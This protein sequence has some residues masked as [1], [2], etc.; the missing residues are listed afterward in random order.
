MTAD[1]APTY[2]A[3][4]VTPA[5][6]APAASSGG[7]GGG[8]SRGTVGKLWRSKSGRVMLATGVALVIV[9]YVFLRRGKAGLSA[10]AAAAAAA[11]TDGGIPAVAPDPLAGLGPGMVNASPIPDG[12]FNFQNPPDTPTDSGSSGGS[13]S[14]A[15]DV[16]LP[17]MTNLPPAT[18][19]AGGGSGTGTA[20]TGTATHTAPAARAKGYY[21]ASFGGSV[22]YEDGKGHARPADLSTAAKKA[23][24]AA[25]AAMHTAMK[26]NPKAG[27][28]NFGLGGVPERVHNDGHFNPAS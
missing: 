8:S 7:S 6:D 15:V 5:H 27:P 20:A 14:I 4:E 9:L 10:P 23:I 24:A 25:D 2:G 18:G 21:R 26:K 22:T 19:T 3:T 1:L 28:V 16:N 13:P 11:P 17:S 12:G